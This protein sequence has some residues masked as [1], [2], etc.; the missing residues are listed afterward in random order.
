MK[1]IIKVPTKKIQGVRESALSTYHRLEY[2]FLAVKPGAERVVDDRVLWVIGELAECGYP[3]RDAR[4]MA[5]ALECGHEHL[6]GR[7]S[8]HLILSC[9]ANLGD[10][11]RAIAFASLKASAPDLAKALGVTRWIAA[12]HDD[13]DHP[14]MHF[15]CWN[16]NPLKDKRLDIRPAYLSQLQDMAWTPH[17]DSGKG[18]REIARSKRGKAV[19]KARKEGAKRLDLEKAPV[20]RKL[21]AFL[22]AKKAPKMGPAELAD[23]LAEVELPP[24]WE[25]HK[26]HTPDGSRRK[27]P[28]III[29]GVG[30]KFSRYFD[31]LKRRQR[32]KGEVIMDM[33]IG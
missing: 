29:D 13:K 18:S 1:A 30:L 19:E 24:G 7:R 12:A 10:Q 15:I 14:H 20:I 31:T 32:Q 26:L 3:V 4:L 17:F 27:D 28:A 8:R 22:K 9:Q 21:K 33:N 2:V 25:K 11:E 6:L 23:W 16:Y 5:E